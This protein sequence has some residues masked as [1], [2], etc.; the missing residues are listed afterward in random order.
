MITKNET[1]QEENTVNTG[2]M[3]IAQL[4]MIAACSLVGAYLAVKQKAIN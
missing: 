2:D 4:F 3:D 1:K